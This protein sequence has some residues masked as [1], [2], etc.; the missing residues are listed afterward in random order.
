M[1]AKDNLAEARRLAQDFLR[2]VHA[3]KQEMIVE[4]TM[5]CGAGEDDF[6]FTAFDNG[7]ADTLGDF[8]GEV[9]RKLREAAEDEESS[10][11]SAEEAADRADYHGRTI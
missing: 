1:S 7:L 6:D 10:I 9:F 2:T 3:A 4:L 11:A 8:H 5:K